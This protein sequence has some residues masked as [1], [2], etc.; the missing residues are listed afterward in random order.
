MGFPLHR[1]TVESGLL[2]CHWHHARFDLASGGTLDPWAD[3][4]PAYA[5][6][7]S[8]GRVTV[9]VEPDTDRVEHL[10]LRLD[11]GLERG[12]TLVVAKAVLGLLGAGVPSEDLVRAGVEFGVRNRQQG[13]GAGLTVLVAMANVLPQLDEGERALALVHGL[14]FLS[15][16]TR[17]RPP[18]FPLAPLDS[19]PDLATVSSWYRRF[20]DSRSADAAER[21]LATAIAAGHGEAA[22]AS[23]MTA[24]ITDHVFIDEGHTLDFTNKAFECLDHLGWTGA[25]RVLPSLV[26]QTAAARRHEEESAWRHPDDLA[27][28]VREA[29]DRVGALAARATDGTGW[30]DRAVDHVAGQ[31]LGEDPATIVAALEAAIGAGATAENLGRAVAYAA[32]LRITRFDTQNDHGDWNTVHHAF[33]AANALHQSLVRSPD[34]ELLRGVYQVALRVYLDRFLNIPAARLP[35]QSRRARA[36]LEPIRDLDELQECWDQEGQVD[37][38]GQIVHGYLVDGGAPGRVVATLGRALLYEDAEFHWFQIYEAAVRQSH[39]W[40]EGSPQQALILAGAARFLAAHTPTRR[41][42]SQ[43]VR[44]AVRLRR[45]EPLYEELPDP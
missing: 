43:V 38:A 16:D 45:G 4:V 2:T 7:T 20:V 34:P 3:D 19:R 9:V 1:G 5:V 29:S 24:A 28:L 40:P 21:T 33:T 26:T 11:E 13:W 31:I 6:E 22:I 42:L 15:G 41:E 14:S 27:A 37:R 36:G 25:A 18:R 12:I 44:I 10:R 32:A 17:G 39:A 35:E 30:R 23:M 8:D